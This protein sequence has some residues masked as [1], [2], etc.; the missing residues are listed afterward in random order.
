VSKIEPYQ[1]YLELRIALYEELAIADSGL[2][3]DAK[4]AEQSKDRKIKDS[5]ARTA[6]AYLLRILARGYWPDDDLR[7]LLIAWCEHQRQQIPTKKRR[8]RPVDSLKEKAVRT[9]YA[10]KVARDRTQ[11]KES[12]VAELEREFGIKRRRVFEIIK[13]TDPHSTLLAA[14]PLGWDIDESF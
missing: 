10:R 2:L 5:A 8:G 7:G 6:L 11:P 3:P 9:A 12:I 13:G 1:P 14:L 4:Y